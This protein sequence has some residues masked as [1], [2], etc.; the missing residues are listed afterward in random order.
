MRR[1]ALALAPSAQADFGLNNFDVTYTNADA[2]TATQAGSHP[3]AM[4]TRLGLNYA[5]AGKE[6]LTEG[7]LRDLFLKQV[8]GFIADTTAYPRCSTLNFLEVNN[9]INNCPLDTQVGITANSITEPGTWLADPVFNLTPPP[10]VRRPR[11]PR[12]SRRQRGERRDRRR[13]RLQP[14]L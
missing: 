7:R 3:F 6:A 5:G 14:A 11:P 2:T 8:P 10:G 9:E 12:L 13:R 4:S 1:L